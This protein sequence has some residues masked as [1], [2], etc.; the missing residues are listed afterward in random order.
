MRVDKKKRMKTL[1]YTLA[2]H[3]LVIPF[4]IMMLG[5]LFWEHTMY[6][7]LGIF[8]ALLWMTVFGR[9]YVNKIVKQKQENDAG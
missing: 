8:I 4:T 7:F 6:I 5:Y 3:T 9:I 1:V 2:I